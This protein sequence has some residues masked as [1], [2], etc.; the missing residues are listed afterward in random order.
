MLKA[1]LVVAV[2]TMAVLGIVCSALSDPT[3][4]PY[5]YSMPTKPLP[6]LGNETMLAQSEMTQNQAE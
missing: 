5:L 4:E 1:Q 6:I 3:F 2:M